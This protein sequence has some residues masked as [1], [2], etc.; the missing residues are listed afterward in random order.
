MT[1]LQA[2]YQDDIL[3]A[4]MAGKRR[5][6]QTTNTDGTISLDD[7]TTYDQVGTDFGASDVNNIVRAIFNHYAGLENS[8]T[9]IVE[10]ASGETVITADNEDAA[11]VTVIAESGGVT[12]ITA[13]IKPKG[14][15]MDNQYVCVTK[16]SEASDGTTT[17][18]KSYSYS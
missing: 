15:G 1:A 10:N 17:I 2:N 16:I 12:T 11:T 7:V 13:T 18:S 4:S 3:N 14:E 6:K 9:S 8:S 5:Y